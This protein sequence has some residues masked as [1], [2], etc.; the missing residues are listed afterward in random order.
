MARP[1]HDPT[2]DWRGSA[3]ADG[4]PLR[5]LVFTDCTFRAMPD[6]HGTHNPT[7]YAQLLA[8]RM[9]RRGVALRARNVFVLR[10]DDLPRTPED[11]VGWNDLGGDP[12]LVFVHTGAMCGMRTVLGM[13]A[14]LQGMRDRMAGKLGPRMVTAYKL[15]WPLARPFSRAAIAMQ[16]PGHLA[17]FAE[18]VERTWPQAR[19]LVMPPFMPASHAPWSHPITQRTRE[20][21][22]AVCESAGIDVIDANAAVLELP[23]HVGRS[24]NGYNLTWEGHERVADALEPHLLELLRRP[25][26]PGPAARTP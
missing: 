12:D 2:R 25:A 17:G 7:G 8:E 21:T 11:L 1:V 10:T 22:I 14:E 23:E 19:L 15:G 13:S 26:T 9:E 24:T 3:A 20:E 6:S 4:Q 5:M 16:E 18:V